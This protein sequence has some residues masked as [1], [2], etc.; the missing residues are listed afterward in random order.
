MRIEQMGPF[1]GDVRSLLLDSRK[2]GAVYLGTS[3]GRIFK[4][5]D[6]GAS[7][8]PLNPGIGPY[9]YVIDT[10]VQHPKEKDRLFAGAW[11]LHSDGGGLFES[12]DAGLTWK[13]VMLPQP[14]S[15]VRGLSVCRKSPEHMI[16][17]TLA[18]VYVSSD[19]GARWKSVG[20]TELQKAE[21]VAID[22]VDYRFLYVGTWRL[23]YRS[24]DFGKTWT[25]V[26]KGMPLDSDVFSLSINR[27]NPEIVYSSACSGVY[28]SRNRA[29]PG[30]G[31]DS[32]PIVSRY[33]RIWS[34]S[35]R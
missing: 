3:N 1:G 20:G 27:Q 29:N 28:R 16:V 25:R 24:A 19:G 2:A 34:T 23:S 18:G 12:S 21:S 32:F 8:T 14:Y 30:P 6:G 13:R 15:A 22:P 7:W 26:E 4:S 17:G 9:R 10:L 5:S 33:A 31:S 35:T 11:D